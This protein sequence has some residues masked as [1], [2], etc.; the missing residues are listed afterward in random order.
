MLS[1]RPDGNRD[2]SK[3]GARTVLRRLVDAAAG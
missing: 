2:L 1:R 3:D